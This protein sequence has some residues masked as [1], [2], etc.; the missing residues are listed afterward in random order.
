MS[1]PISEFIPS[2]LSSLGVQMFFLYI[3]VSI[4][5]LQIGS[6]ISFFYIP[7]IW[8]IIWCLFSSFWLISLLTGESIGGK[9]LVTPSPTSPSFGRP[10]GPS[11][12]FSWSKL[13]ALIG[14]QFLGHRSTRWGV[15]RYLV[16]HRVFPKKGLNCSWWADKHQRWQLVCFSLSQVRAC[17]I[18]LHH[19]GKKSRQSCQHY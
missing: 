2:S 8:I 4:S 10:L 6:S 14:G 13:L 15:A 18:F 19:K 12:L 17:K 11:A 5:A 16:C 7:H 1:G 9:L 3:Y